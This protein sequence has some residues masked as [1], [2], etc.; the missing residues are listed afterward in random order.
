MRILVYID[1]PAVSDALKEWASGIDGEVQWRNG[2]YFKRPERRVAQVV[3]DLEEVRRAYESN[4]VEVKPMPKPGQKGT[5]ATSRRYVAEDKGRWKKVKDRKTG[6]YVDGAS[7][8]SMDKA[9]QVADKL[10]NG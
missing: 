7:R 2:Q 6:E 3:T 1:G 4:D 9:Q 10:N 5:E 8:R